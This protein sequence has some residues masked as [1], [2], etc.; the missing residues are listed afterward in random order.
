MKDEWHTEPLVIF[1]FKTAQAD[2]TNFGS[3][4]EEEVNIVVKILNFV[5]NLCLV[6][7]GSRLGG[8][9]L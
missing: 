1:P 5:L 4:W 7:I 2:G 3:D 6:L 9:N 8:K